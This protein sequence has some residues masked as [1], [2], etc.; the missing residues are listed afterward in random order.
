M[1]QLDCNYCDVTVEGDV[2]QVKRDAKTHLEENHAEDVITDLKDEHTEIPCQNKCG[3]TV[4]IG[5][6]NV[7]GV[8]CPEC[9]HDNFP[10]LVKQYVFWRITEEK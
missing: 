10:L 5:V 9:G 8:E 3:Y 7:A 4:P 6:G 2:E 1:F